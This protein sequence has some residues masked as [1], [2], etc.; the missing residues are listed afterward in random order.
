MAFYAAVRVHHCIGKAVALAL[1]S[2]PLASCG[3]PFAPD[4]NMVDT[5]AV[6][7]KADPQVR[8][9]YAARNGQVAWNGSA[10]KQLLEIIDGAPSHGLKRELFLKGDLPDD[11]SEREIAL[12]KAALHYASALARGYS[13]PNKFGRTY[14]IARPKADVA[15]GLAGALQAGKLADWYASLAPQT[16]EYRLLSQDLVRYLRMANDMGNGTALPPAAA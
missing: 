16:E 2:V 9:F 15:A 4:P 6:G 8:A 12:T 13:D 3:N 5:E 10:R 14:T 11:D 1:F 7:A